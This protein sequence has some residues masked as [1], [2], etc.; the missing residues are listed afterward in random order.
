MKLDF[1]FYNMN[2]QIVSKYKTIKVILDSD[3]NFI[4]V[5]NKRLKIIENYQS[6]YTYQVQKTQIKTQ[7]KERLIKH[8]I[9]ASKSDSVFNTMTYS[10]LS[11]IGAWKNEVR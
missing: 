7:D 1:N 5:N 8:I 6:E 3:N 2:G 4:Q 10:L 11:K 9:D